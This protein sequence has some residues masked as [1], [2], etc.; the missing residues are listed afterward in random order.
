ME[1]IKIGS[2]LKQELRGFHGEKVKRR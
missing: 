2:F 1:M